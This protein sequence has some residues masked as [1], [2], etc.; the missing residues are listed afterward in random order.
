MPVMLSLRHWGLAAMACVAFAGCR[1]DEPPAGPAAAGPSA[2]SPSRGA[3]LADVTEAVGLAFHHFI[4]ATGRFYF[5][6]IM[7]A[8]CGVF[9]YDNDGDLDI[10]AVQGALLD[11][12]NTLE[13]AIFPFRGPGLPRNVLYRNDLVRPGAADEAGRGLH[14][15][16]V[17]ETSG[18]GH[19]GYGMGCAVGDYDNDGF[20]DLY[21]TNYGPNVLYHNNGDG[22]FSDVTAQAGVDDSRWSSSA[23]FADLNGDGLL[24]LY[25]ANYVDW[26]LAIDRACYSST[27][28]RDYCSPITYKPAGDNL[29][30]QRAGGRFENVT[31]Q[32]GIDRDRGNGLGVVCADFDGDGLTDIY[33]ANDGTPNFLWIAHPDGTF[34]D[35]ALLAGAAVNDGGMPEAGMGVTAQDFD[36]DRDLDIF[37]NNLKDE[38][39]TLYLNDGRGL[40]EDAT[41]R[42]ALAVSSRLFTGFGTCWFDYDND[43][44]LDLFSANGAVYYL[45]ALAGDPYPYHQ[46]NTLWHHTGSA[47]APRFEDVSDRGGP[48]F[49]ISEVSR[50]AAFGDIDNDGDIDVVVSNQNAPLR[51]LR[52]EVGA[53]GH[54]LSVRLEGRVSNRSAIGARVALSLPDGGTLWRRVHAE[55]SYCS[56]NDLR[57]HFGLGQATSCGDLVVHWPSGRVESWPGPAVDTHV[58]LREGK[59]RALP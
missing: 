41:I 34:V 51:L 43:G 44:R 3:I 22:T 5:P 39:S 10:Y 38:T 54:W 2:S 40:F 28:V 1:K 9:D 52:N 11:Q 15:T 33:V 6:E 24:D 30:F 20:V 57:V 35:R 26:R 48:H 47:G 42:F 45:D 4:G 23:A 37:V 17:T 27:G 31:A 29:F 32:T 58:H 12:E 8:G 50:G 7:G 25:V 49:G 16:D 36:G 53:Q 56:A 14:F 21:V 55:G 59:G 19:T 18:V 13:Q 46:P